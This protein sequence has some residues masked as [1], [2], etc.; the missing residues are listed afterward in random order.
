MKRVILILSITLI[1]LYAFPQEFDNNELVYPTWVI[2][3][4]SYKAM[5]G[6]ADSVLVATDGAIAKVVWN[7][8][9]DVFADWVE[10]VHL[11]FD[12]M[13][14]QPAYFAYFSVKEEYQSNDFEWIFRKSLLNKNDFKQPVLQQVPGEELFL[15]IFLHKKMNGYGYS[16]FKESGKYIGYAIMIFP[17]IYDY[18]KYPIEQFYI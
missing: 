16:L 12:Y 3:V 1:G 18:K 8:D 14:G 10:S 17:L 2:L 5:F 4:E 15:E 9:N 7:S 11:S 6:E 13:K